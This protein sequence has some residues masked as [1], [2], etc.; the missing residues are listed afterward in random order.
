MGIMKCDWFPD[1]S[2]FV[3]CSSD[4]TLKIFKPENL[5]QVA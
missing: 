3:T 1:S 2:E 4:Q 5:E